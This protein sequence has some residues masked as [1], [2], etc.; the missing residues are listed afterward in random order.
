MKVA[1]FGLWG[2]RGGGRGGHKFI[3]YHDFQPSVSVVV[4]F[5]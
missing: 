1:G 3:L 4:P 2:G 5:F